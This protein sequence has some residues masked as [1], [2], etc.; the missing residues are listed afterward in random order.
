M[1]RL[2]GYAREYVT[3]LPSTFLWR[4]PSSTA[5]RQTALAFWVVVISGIPRFTM[6]LVPI[7]SP[8]ALIASRTSAAKRSLS[9][10]A[11]LVCLARG[12]VMLASILPSTSTTSGLSSQRL[13]ARAR[14]SARV[15]PLFLVAIVTT[16]LPR[17]GYF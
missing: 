17:R 15:I 12:L 14:A 8:W 5:T 2:R 11:L 7:P 3:V 1:P 16:F 13:I 6:S 4:Y 9:S 10:L